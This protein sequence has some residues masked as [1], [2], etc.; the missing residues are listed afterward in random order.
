MSIRLPMRRCAPTTAIPLA[1]TLLAARKASGLSQKE[2]ARRLFVNA[3][4]LTGWESGKRQPHVDMIDA[5]LKIV[6]GS[7]TLG[8]AR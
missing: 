6:G 7:I 3:T 1:A 2:V 5:Y 8:A 4:T